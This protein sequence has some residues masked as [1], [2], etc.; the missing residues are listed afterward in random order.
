MNGGDASPDQYVVFLVMKAAG[1]D[2]NG[3]SN[4]RTER[5]YHANGETDVVASQKQGE[6][7]R[8]EGDQLT[9]VQIRS[10]RER[11]REK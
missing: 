8:E 9:K 3:S 4:V 6:R 10:D 7:K 1:I 5:N 2:T 11:E